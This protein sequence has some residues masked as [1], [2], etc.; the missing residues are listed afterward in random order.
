MIALFWY[1]VV[2]DSLVQVEM[3]TPFFTP[4]VKMV[5][6]GPNKGGFLLHGG[7]ART[8]SQ[9]N[10]TVDI[11]WPSSVIVSVLEGWDVSNGWSGQH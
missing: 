9:A 1:E 6:I 4:R 10:F 2:R 3:W 5:H 11:G 7:S 8:G